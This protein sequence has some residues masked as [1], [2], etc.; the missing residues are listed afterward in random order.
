MRIVMRLAGVIVSGLLFTAPVAR[1]AEWFV[2]P[3]TG[4]ITKV[5][6]TGAA[7][8]DTLTLG[9]GTYYDNVSL[10]D[11][12]WT[13]RSVV[14]GVAVL[15]GTNTDSVIYARTGN[16]VLD[17]LILQHGRGHN[18][19][20]SPS[21]RAGGAVCIRGFEHFSS[22][23]AIECVF[24]DNEL[25]GSDQ[26]LHGGAVYAEGLVWCV[27]EACV[28]ERNFARS[29]G[30]DVEFESGGMDLRIERCVFRSGASVDRGEGMVVGPIDGTTEV[31]DSQFFGPGSVG[32]GGRY[33]DVE[34]CWF[35]GAA[36]G[37]SDWNLAVPGR[38]RCVSNFLVGSPTERG[39]LQPTIV[40]SEVAFERNT[41][42]FVDVSVWGGHAARYTFRANALL[43]VS[44]SFTLQPG[45]SMTC[46]VAWPSLP[47]DYYGL[48]QTDSTVVIVDPAFCDSTE[49]RLRP[50]SPCLD[51]TL[52]SE[53]IG[54]SEA[55]DESPTLRL[56]WGALK[57]R[58]K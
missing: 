38:V 49:W 20:D 31:R 56:G 34:R 2:D 6:A 15:D 18:Y 36:L 24:R 37:F 40:A 16:L 47:E 29:G 44:G 28:F 58:F 8:G 25:V 57:D 23:T 17:G 51:G 48:L 53:P 33:I 27:L 5:L 43:D 14:P 13:L 9:K 55:C 11:G 50:N 39:R 45:S 41:I 3:G 4:T 52:C 7:P 22:L 19:E 42:A 35:Q 54:A 32:F 46:T 30:T 26:V 10:P 21:F 12:D 1:A